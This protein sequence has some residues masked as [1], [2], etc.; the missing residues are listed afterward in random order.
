MVYFF[1]FK[2][3]HFYFSSKQAICYFAKDFADE[4]LK[5]EHVALK[6]RLEELAMEFKRIFEECQANA[7]EREYLWGR[8]KE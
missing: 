5:L 3:R 6:F 1:N 7:E 8:G 2:S 4:S